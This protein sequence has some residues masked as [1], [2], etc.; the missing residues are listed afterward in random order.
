MAGVRVRFRAITRVRV[1]SRIRLLVRFK[2]SVRVGLG[3]GLGLWLGELISMRSAFKGKI[4]TKEL[5]QRLGL[6]LGE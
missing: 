2:I 3:I 5:H 4:H 1:S 6:G